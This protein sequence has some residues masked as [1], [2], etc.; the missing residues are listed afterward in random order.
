MKLSRISIN[1]YRIKI[2]VRDVKN[3]VVSLLCL[4]LTASSVAQENAISE[5]L[6]LV[7]RTF[8]IEENDEDIKFVFKENGVV[9]ISG[10]EFGDGVEGSYTQDKED[11]LIKIG[12]EEIFAFFDGKEFEFEEPEYYPPGYNITA[13]G[14]DAYEAR[15]YKSS[16]GDT[17]QYRLFIPENYNE[18]IIYPLV[19]FHHGAGGTGND[20]I[21]NLEGPCPMEWAGPERH[22]DNPCFIV[23]PQIPRNDKERSE[24]GRPRTDIMNVHIKTIHEILYRL[25]KE[26]SIDK[27]RE[28]VTG[29][30]MGGECTWMSMIQRPDRF[31]AAIPICGGDWIIGMSAEERGKKFAQ[32]PMWIFHGEADGV[33]SVDVSRES[34]KQLRA[35]GG[36]PKYT[37]YLGVGHDSWTRA[38]RDQELID[39]LFAQ[40]RK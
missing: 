17:I 2:K 23:A 28:Y 34:V 15:K 16:D 5:D 24:S 12:N 32:L 6:S 18:D 19:L 4:M 26:F 9:F 31:A 39:W 13:V 21:H 40:S 7:G 29:L 14:V 35:A 3:V 25:E 22:A 11:V 20:N 37:E 27:D 1:F 8:T 33:V 30:S 38:Y 36:S 10:S